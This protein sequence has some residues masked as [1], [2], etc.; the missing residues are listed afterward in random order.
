MLKAHFDECRVA[1]SPMQRTAL[2]EHRRAEQLFSER[3]CNT[4][5]NDGRRQTGMPRAALVPPRPSI[6]GQSRAELGRRNRP[7]GES[8]CSCSTTT[9]RRSERGTVGPTTASAGNG[10]PAAVSTRRPVSA[11][12][13]PARSHAA[14]T[15]IRRDDTSSGH[16]CR[17]WRDCRTTCCTRPGSLPRSLP[18]QPLTLDRGTT[19]CRIRCFHRRK[20]PI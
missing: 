18:P 1:A 15:E 2:H 20:Q 4:A 14:E 5:A 11:S 16:G 13:T 8:R 9:S 12:S 19:S 17:N 10:W 6:D 7:T 3:E